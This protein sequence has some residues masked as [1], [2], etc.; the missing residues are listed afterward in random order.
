MRK[1]DVARSP[2]RCPDGE[3]T[4]CPGGLQCFGNTGCY[5]G[6]DLV[7]TVTPVTAPSASPT[8]AAPVDYKD[9][10][11]VRFC[12][13]V[14]P[15][16]SMH[17][18]ARAASH[19]E[20]LRRGAR[21]FPSRTRGF[22]IGSRFVKRLRSAAGSELGARPRELQPGDALPLRI[23]VSRASHEPR[24]ATFAFVGSSLF[25]IFRDRDE[26]PKGQTCHGGLMDC[27]IIDMQ[28]KID[29][30][31]Y[32]TAIPTMAPYSYEDP[33]NSKFVSE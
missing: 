31:Q 11:N 8:T 33:K 10:G 27:N 12:V 28:A 15:T 24:A 14:L 2:D 30:P 13:S 32:P 22:A 20:P 5:Y 21:P 16:C 25:S 1:P 4:S 9:P 6:D 19:F 3:K 23:R 18:R 26:C 7:P 17:G 29:Q